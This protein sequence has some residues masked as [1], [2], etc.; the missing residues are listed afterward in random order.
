MLLVALWDSYSCLLQDSGTLLK[1]VKPKLV[2]NKV[3][4]VYWNR[5]DSR[6]R[7]LLRGW[8]TNAY[9]CLPL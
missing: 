4:A 5:I 6:K 1:Y 8:Q 3:N 9:H 7:Y 2:G